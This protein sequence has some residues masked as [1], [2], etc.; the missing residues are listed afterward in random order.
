MPRRVRRGVPPSDHSV[1][2]DV[3]MAQLDLLRTRLDLGRVVVGHADSYPSLDYYRRCWPAGRRC[4]STTSARSA[5]VHG[6]DPDLSRRSW[7]KARSPHRGLARRVQ[8]RHAELPRRPRLRVRT[9]RGPARPAPWSD[10]AAVEDLWSPSPAASSPSPRPPDFSRWSVTRWPSI[11]YRES[12]S[13][14]DRHQE[15]RRVAIRSRSR[16]GCAVGAGAAQQADGEVGHLGD[17]TSGATSAGPVA[18]DAAAA[19]RR[20]YRAAQPVSIQPGAIA[21]T[22]TPGGA[23]DARFSV[24]ARRAAFDTA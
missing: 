5:A 24:R 16:T 20:H 17:S 8:A 12:Q 14:T 23:M 1:G 22:D 10:D 18:S 21:Q 3:A 2:S 15:L 4:P 9:R 11:R 19:R 6:A 13:V 7:A